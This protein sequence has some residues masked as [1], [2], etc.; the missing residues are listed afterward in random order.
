LSVG[1]EEEGKKEN[2]YAFSHLV[3]D[4]KAGLI[5]E[6]NKKDGYDIRR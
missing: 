4:I 1:N 3:E 2:R 5:Q 6:G